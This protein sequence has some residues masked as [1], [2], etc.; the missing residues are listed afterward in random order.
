MMNGMIGMQAAQQGFEHLVPVSAAYP[1]ARPASRL[2]CRT[3][4]ASSR[5]QSQYSFQVNS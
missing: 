4:L 5:Y 1:A 2:P 3:G